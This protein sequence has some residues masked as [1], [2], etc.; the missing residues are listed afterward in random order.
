MQ[1]PLAG[2]EFEGKYRIVARIGRGGFANVYRARELALDRDVA[3]KVLS[4]RDGAYPGNLV[5]RFM[6]EARVIAGLHSDYTIRLYEFGQTPAGLLYMVFQFVEGC[7]LAE[8]IRRQRRLDPPVVIHIL[9]QVLYALKE[10]HGAGVLHRDIK[11]ANI[12]V[13]EHL[14]DPYTVKL[15]DFGVAKVKPTD[16]SVAALTKTGT[17]IGTPRYVAPEQIFGEEMTP[18]SDIYSLGLVAWEMLLGKPTVDGSSE[19]MLRAQVDPQSFVLPPEIAWPSLRAVVEKM[20]A[21]EVFERFRSADEVLAALERTSFDDAELRQ[22]QVRRPPSGASRPARQPT[23]AMEQARPARLGW[24]LPTGI[25]AS[26]TVGLLGAFL[27]MDE[28][29]ET[30]RPG[31]PVRAV[32]PKLVSVDDAPTTPPAEDEA[33]PANSTVEDVGPDVEP[34]FTDDFPD[35]CGRKVEA[36]THR[37]HPIVVNGK[38]RMARLYIPAKYDP[39]QRYPVVIVF[40]QRFKEVSYHM[41]RTR[42]SHLAVRD[43][44]FVAVGVEITDTAKYTLDRRAW[45]APTE[46]I[47]IVV[48]AVRELARTACIDRTM[49]FAT[50]EEDGARMARE[51]A[52][53]VPISGAMLVSAGELVDAPS[54]EP[55]HP[56]PIMWVQGR[57]DQYILERGGFGCLGDD[58]MSILDRDALWKERNG[59]RGASRDFVDD[60]HGLCITWDCSKAQYVSCTMDGGHV[61]EKQTGWKFVDPASCQSAPMKTLLGPIAWKFWE[62]Y[63]R[64]LDPPFGAPR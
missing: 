58:Y 19:E 48:E 14:G 54:C 2:E 18:A 52:C 13:H 41:N 33:V 20:L 60:E 42:L 56:T 25:A 1:L 26:V 39:R 7:D 63:G 55:V 57:D 38:N 45:E 35:G 53:H 44:K 50:G 10:A 12:L 32:P 8:L 51:F 9:R 64:A 37:E 22:T 27:F 21:K 23:R 61:L 31:P 62:R 17:L 40:H 16:P 47:P 15:L 46:E 49:V 24:V 5:A 30:A 43:G 3:I 11:P 36:L 59:C 4:P 28:G 6:T 29:D 34:L